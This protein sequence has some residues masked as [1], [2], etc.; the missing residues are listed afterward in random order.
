[1]NW[2]YDTADCAKQFGV[3]GDKITIRSQNL[4]EPYSSTIQL[5]TAGQYQLIEYLVGRIRE[6]EARRVDD[7][8]K[9]ILESK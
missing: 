7:R 8:L 1:M 6:K 4:D 2:L 3:D 5:D 9:K